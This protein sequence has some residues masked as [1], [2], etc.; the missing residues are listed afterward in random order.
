MG[1]DDLASGWAQTNYSGNLGSQHAS[2]ADP[3][4]NLFLQPSNVANGF[5]GHYFEATGWADHGNTGNPQ[6]ISGTFNRLGMCI[7]IR[8]IIDG[9][10]N[11]ILV[12]EILPICSGDHNGGAW[13]FNGMGNAHSSTSVP[14]NEMTTCQGNP[15]PKYPA[16]T[17]W[18]NWNLAWGFRSLHAGGAQFLLGDGSVQFFSENIDYKT[19]QKLGGRNDR[20]P[21]QF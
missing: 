17:P 1:L 8:D 15:N 19:Y 14:I 20:Q 12:G 18:S 16:C 21:V 5:S 3:A 4:C 13:H 9:T 7:G 2:S 11:V 10:T 6:G